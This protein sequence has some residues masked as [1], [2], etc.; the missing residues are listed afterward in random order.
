MQVQVGR[1][2][3]SG[4]TSLQNSQQC[5]CRDRGI[6]QGRRNW[7]LES[8]LTGCGSRQTSEIAVVGALPTRCEVQVAQNL[9]AVANLFSSVQEAVEGLC[10]RWPTTGRPAHLHF[11]RYGILVFRC[12]LISPTLHFFL[13]LS[14][15]TVNETHGFVRM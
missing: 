9:G 13:A 4:Q 2:L 12:R 15:L 10:N 5:T 3:V 14:L 7:H 1:H 6:R 8:R 11:S